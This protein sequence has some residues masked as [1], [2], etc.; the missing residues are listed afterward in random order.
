PEVFDRVMDPLLVDFMS[1]KSSL[2]VAMG[3]TGSGKTHTMFGTYYISMFEIYSERGKGERILDLCPDGVDLS[4][5]QLTIKGLREVM[6]STL[7]EAESLV[8]CGMLK[9][10]TAATNA[11]SHR[12]QCIINIRCDRKSLLDGNDLSLGS[13]VLTIADLA[14]AEREKKT[15]NQGSRLLES[16]FINN[17]S[18][19]FGLCLRSLLEHQKNPRK[20]LQKHFKNSLLTRYLR[21]YL[22]GRKRMTL[23]LA[24]FNRELLPTRSSQIS[25]ME[26]LM[27]QKKKD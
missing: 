18:M 20:P 9:R 6:I 17:T 23:K 8:A 13:A 24:P 2:L 4:I 26:K 25:Q 21:D 27:L 16:N 19:V 10:T 11:N 15:G 14:G 1:G 5:H 22:E 3:P 7:A 12:S